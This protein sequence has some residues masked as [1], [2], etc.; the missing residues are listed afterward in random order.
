MSHRISHKRDAFAVY[1][2]LEGSMALLLSLIFTVNMVYQATVVGLNPL[3]LVLVGTML[4]TVIFIFEVPTGVVADVYSR[5][6]SVIIGVFLIGIGFMLEGLVPRFGAVLAAQ[7]LWGLGATFTSG[8][9]QAW[10]ADEVGEERVGRAFLRGSQIGQIGGLVGIVLS[11][12]LASVRINLP[13]V[14]SGVMIVGLGLL[15]ALIMPEN[16]VKL[17]PSQTRNSWR[18]MT[19]TFWGG[20]RLVRGRAILMTFLGMSAITGL[21]SEGFDRLWT[22]HLLENFTFPALDGFKPIVWFGIIHIVSMGLSI[23]AAEILQRRIDTTDQLVVARAMIVMNALTV[24]SLALF[25]LAGSFGLVLLAFWTVQVTRTLSGPL[26]M[27]WMNRHIESEVRATV[28]SMSSQVN[29]IGQIAGGPVVGVIGTVGSLRAA[30][31]TSGL[32]LSPILLLLA[33]GSRQS[34]ETPVLTVAAAPE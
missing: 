14:L 27:A 26:S 12:A 6:L 30:L 18:T 32:I 25:G 7:V 9:T 8:A 29:A 4:E 17:T 24:G 2:L 5:R 3:Q 33:R 21:Y 10:I 11:V 1:L 31:V 20:I 34:Q 16:G 23:A 19:Q 28:F 15:L 22:A 13:I